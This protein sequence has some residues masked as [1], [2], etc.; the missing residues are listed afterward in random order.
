LHFVRYHHRGMEKRKV[1]SIESLRQKK[2]A[3]RRA[4]EKELH[5]ALS[6]TIDTSRMTGEAQPLSPEEEL[7]IVQQMRE[8][9]EEEGLD[10]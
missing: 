10:E 8:E 5:D 3:E 4:K 7:H 2:E 9:V 6:D 1:V